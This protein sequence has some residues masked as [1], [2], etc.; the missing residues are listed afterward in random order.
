MGFYMGG[1]LKAPPPLMDV[2]SRGLMV[3]LNLQQEEYTKVLSTCFYLD[4]TLLKSSE[5]INIQYKNDFYTLQKLKKSV[6]A[7]R[8][9]ENLVSSSIYPS[10]ITHTYSDPPNLKVQSHQKIFLLTAFSY[11]HKV[12]NGKCS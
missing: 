3:G 7:F 9:S 1:A 6:F 8:H 4:S 11:I 12:K 2:N 10:C 5:S